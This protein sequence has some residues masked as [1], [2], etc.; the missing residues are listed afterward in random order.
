MKVILSCKELLLDV[1]AGTR[2]WSQFTSFIDA[3]NSN[4]AVKG[5]YLVDEP[6]D[7][8]LLSACQTGYNI[9]HGKSNPKPVY[10]DF[11]WQGVNLNAPYNYRNTYDVMMYDHYPYG[12][13]EAEFMRFKDY[14]GVWGGKGWVSLSEAAMAQ[15]SLAGKPFINVLQAFKRV[16]SG[17]NGDWWRLPTLAEERFTTFWS[18]VKGSEGVSFWAMDVLDQA[19]ADATDLYPKD[20]TAWRNEVALPIGRELEKLQNAF[21]AGPVLN[22]VGDNSTSVLS[23]VYRDTE[24][25]KY[26][27]VAV[28]SGDGIQSALFNIDSSLDNLLKAVRLDGSGEIAISGGHFSDTFGAYGVGTYELMLVPTSLTWTGAVSTTWSTGTVTNWKVAS[29][30]ANRYIES[31]DVTF[32]DTAIATTVDISTADLTPNGVIFSNSS[33]DFTVQGSKG[34]AGSTG[35]TKT[36]TGK[37]TITA[38]NTYTGLTTVQAGTLQLGVNAYSPVLGTG[39]GGADI[40]GGK[41]VFDYTGGSTPASSVL[42]ALTTSYASGFASGKIRSSTATGSVGLGWLDDTTAHQ[43][44]VARALYGDV[45]LSGAVDFSD[46]GIFLTNYNHSGNWSRGDFNYD[47]TVSFADLGYLLTNY[48]HSLSGPS[49]DPAS[50]ALDARAI[51]ALSQ[52]GI[53]MVPEPSALVLLFGGGVSLLVTP[54]AARNRKPCRQ[55]ASETRRRS[56]IAWRQRLMEPENWFSIGQRLRR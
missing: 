47:G 34:I 4:P 13:G 11:E 45:N 38:A 22:G 39:G 10:A 33:K 24:N 50:Y 43:L 44:T 25:G 5:W 42:S 15:A 29:G 27:L 46:L 36:G 32:N 48:N 9:I 35:I 54:I 2:T 8:S 6:T 49:L 14:P 12:I 16:P 21:D 20:G 26:Y 18:V 41:L 17:W 3:F 53:T 1:N 30:T 40:R 31:S 19:A 28:N 55:I 7:T 37:V 52:A 51:E 23:K 56:R